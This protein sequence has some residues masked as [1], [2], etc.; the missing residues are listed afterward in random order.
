MDLEISSPGVSRMQAA[1]SIDLAAHGKV[2]GCSRPC[3]DMA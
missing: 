3:R 1:E 2:H